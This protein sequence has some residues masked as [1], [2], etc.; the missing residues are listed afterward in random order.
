MSAEYEFVPAF[1]DVGAHDIAH[2]VVPGFRRSPD[3]MGLSDA[4]RLRA[5]TAAAAYD[6]LEL[7]ERRGVIVVSGY[8]AP[9]DNAG[10]YW[11]DGQG[12]I[13]MGRPEAI[14]MRN[15]ITSYCHF[16]TDRVRT[17]P[18][19][20]TTLSSLLRSEQMLPDDRPVGIVAQEKQLDRIMRHVAPRVMG[21][22]GYV[23][24]IAP[25][26]ATAEAQEEPVTWRDRL[27]NRIVAAGIKEASEYASI[28]ADRRARAIYGI[29]SLTERIRARF[30]E[31]DVE[32]VSQI[33]S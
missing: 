6:D 22:R 33:A 31:E 26:P 8:K 5:Y 24:I 13:F 14:S 25:E 21:H 9:N 23:G 17:E 15:Y 10:D 30:Q 20:L 2:L 1:E 11:A 32:P 12:N 19:S 3:G 27:L 29:A 16:P 7:D 28:R 18:H 4:S